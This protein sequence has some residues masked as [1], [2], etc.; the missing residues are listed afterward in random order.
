MWIWH[1][2]FGF[3]GT[4]NDI[5]IW[6]Q[7]SLLRMFL[8]GTFL[9]VD[10][11]FRIGNKTFDKVW[12]MVDGIYPELSRFVKT[13]SIPVNQVQKMYSKWQEACQSKPLVFYDASSRYC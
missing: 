12:I 11:S 6:D 10:F 5:N 4:H 2:R 8:D 3:P 13:I 9:N 1:T 7:S